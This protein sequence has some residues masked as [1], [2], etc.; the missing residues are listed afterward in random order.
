MKLIRY[1]FLRG[2]L[3]LGLLVHTSLGAEKRA[4][5]KHEKIDEQIS[6]TVNSNVKQYSTV[7]CLMVC[8]GN[9]D[10]LLKVAKLLKFDL[11]FT[12]QLD[13]EIKKHE[14]ELDAEKM[15]KLSGQGFSLCLSLQE[16]AKKDTHKKENKKK[17]NTI[18]VEI[19]LKDPSTNQV[20]F[21][22][23]VRWSDK[24]A[25]LDAH[26]MAEQLLPVLT[27][28]KGP[29]LSTLAYCKQLSSKHKIIC[30]ADY[31][32]MKERVLV[33]NYTLNVAP[34]WHS[35][36]PILFFSQFTR[37]NSRLMSVDIASKQQR[38][39]C[40][41]DG[42]NMQPSFSQDGV[43][44]VLCLSGSGN[45][46]L[47]FYDQT[48]CNKLKKRIFTPL[49]SNKGSNVS[50]CL[51]PNGDV[52]FCSDYQTGYPQIYYLDMKKKTTRVLTSGRGYCASP[53]YSIDTHSIIYSRYVRGVF[54]LFSLDIQAKNPRERQ[55]TF[56]MGDKLDPVWSPCG[57]YAAFSFNC[58]DKKGQQVAA[59]NCRSGK[60][61]VLTM[62]KEPKSFPS[63]T[64]MQLF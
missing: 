47:Y 60:V 41:Y 51:L 27:G 4:Q 11:E 13:V 50:P 17:N 44:A 56:G 5:E 40:S 46:E 33:Q 1:S 54:Q 48:V 34:C 24:T 43:Q 25:I 31:A 3:V 62:G 57:K 35:K 64:S 49:T 45:S 19:K 63:W 10:E 37:R 29:M 15:A 8:V 20:F 30:V 6:F 55:L 42:L 21:D 26:I 58:P 2:L 14:T 39:V 38:V 23:K 16:I 22:K 61:R 59:L 12:D 9:S 32:C 18:D 52:V 53:S 28:E 7:K 36:A